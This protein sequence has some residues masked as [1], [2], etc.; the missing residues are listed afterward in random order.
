MA[1][2]IQEQKEVYRRQLQA[3]VDAALARYENQQKSNLNTKLENAQ[4]ETAELERGFD[5][6]EAR[7][8]AKLLSDIQAMTTAYQQDAL[9]RGMTRST[10]ALDRNA[11]GETSLRLQTADSIARAQREMQAQTEELR[12]QQLQYQNQ[13]MDNTA[14]ERAAQE[15]SLTAKLSQWELS[16]LEEAAKAEAEA[17]AKNAHRYIVVR[18]AAPQEAAE[19]QPDQA[20]K[21]KLNEAKFT[22]LYQRENDYMSRLTKTPKATT[23]KKTASGKKW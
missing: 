15:N 8:T 2:T 17:A 13:Y 20:T 21:L 7:S 19:K 9:R 3:E 23:D 18:A 4:R 10:Y 6:Y 16:K 11:E 14:V 12:R 5:D 1:A 22:N